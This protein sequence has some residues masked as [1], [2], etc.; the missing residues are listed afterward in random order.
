M[1]GNPS[2]IQGFK[3]F[4]LRGNVVDLAVAVV[5]GAAFATVV[6]SVVDGV[7]TPVVAA[8][9]GESKLDG[10][11]AFT[12]NHAN[13]SLGLIL[14]AI[15]NFLA[16]AAVVYFLVVV[17]VN[18]LLARFAAGEEPAAAPDPQ[19]VLLGEIRDLLAGEPAP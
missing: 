4:V 3:S 7:I 8:V 9:F 15:I 6:K 5:I 18:R 1:A 11:G 17:P 14:A 19:L 16:V 12:I 10:V 13:F 2:L